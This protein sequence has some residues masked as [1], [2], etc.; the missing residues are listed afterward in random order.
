[1]EERKKDCAQV[2]QTVFGP[3]PYVADSDVERSVSFGANVQNIGQT[4][5]SANSETELDT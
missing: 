1:M 3:K 2:A 5:Q 4:S